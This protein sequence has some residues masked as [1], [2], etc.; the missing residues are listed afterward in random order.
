MSQRLKKDQRG[1]AFV[2]ALLIIVI[3]GLVAGVGYY[4]VKQR[5]NGVTPATSSAPAA[6]SPSTTATVT[7]SAGTTD[8]IDQLTQADAQSEDSINSKYEK[9]TQSAA[10]SDSTALSNLGGAYNESNY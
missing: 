2:E 6:S 1:F 5:S 4:V 3:I 8:A 9:Q 7:A 10:T